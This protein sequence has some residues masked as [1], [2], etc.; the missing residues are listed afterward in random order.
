MRISGIGA[1]FPS[2]KVSNDKVLQLLEQQS[3]DVFQGSLKKLLRKTEIILR[4]TGIES[5][6][7]L[8]KDETLMPHIENAYGMAMKMSGLQESDVDMCI[9]ASVD[10][11]FFEPAQASVVAKQLNL[12]H[13]QCFDILEAC[14]S[15]TRALEIACQFLQ[16]KTYRNILII[17]SEFTANQN[18]INFK[19]YTIKNTEEFQW[20]FPSMTIGEC[21]TATVLS[22][23]D[24]KSWKFNFLSI[25]E[26]AQLCY[27]LV[28][29]IASQKRLFPLNAG[30]QEEAM[31]YS[32]SVQMKK[33]GA[34]K[35][36]QQYCENKQF[37]DGVH[38]IF[39]HTHEIQFWEEL[40]APLNWPF[41]YIFKERGNLVASGI[42]A[43]IYLAMMEKKIQEQDEIGIMMA[44]AGLS[45]ALVRFTF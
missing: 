2:L 20:K 7:W 41:Y 39:P 23:D 35:I 37:F 17:T 25:P 24:R 6:Y 9:Y 38:C 32:Q 12:K 36:W 21:A 26:H 45:S 5:R 30:V 11:Q 44:S 16:S 42:P 13:C 31:F 19:N 8:D 43:A 33:I 27:T 22:V 3:R 4:K 40:F 29:G 34:Q 28:P 10:K 18:T 1:S 15:W 14:M